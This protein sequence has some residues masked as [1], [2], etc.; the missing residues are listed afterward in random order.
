MDLES[1]T[2]D[3][4]AHTRIVIGM[5][6]GLG[7]TRTLLT[8]ANIIQTPKTHT[9]SL[10]HLLWLGA[11][12][13]ELALFWYI[14][15]ELVLL[16]HWN[17]GY[18]AF[19]VGYAIVLYMQTALL[20][21]DRAPDHGGY[22][23]FFIER[24]HWFFGFFIASQVFDILDTIFLAP[25]EQLEPADLIVGGVFIVLGLAGWISKKR[26]VHYTIITLHML[27]LAIVSFFYA[28]ETI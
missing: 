10:L 18:F 28:I 22:Q 6:I 7:I 12:L 16:P 25:K 8:F 20:T 9:R 24:R 15:I 21:S 3:L 26:R 23:E 14:H 19:Y 11:M 17:F 5:V 4:F 27:G 2:V 13:V 1:H